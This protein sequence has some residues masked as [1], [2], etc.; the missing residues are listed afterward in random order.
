MGQAAEGT[1]TAT[2]SCMRSERTIRLVLVESFKYG[3][4]V[5]APY[6][7]EQFRGLGVFYEDFT[8]LSDESVISEL[9]AFRHDVERAVS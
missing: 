3:A 2:F 1:S 7:S 4:C 5:D 6:I 9:L 8:Q